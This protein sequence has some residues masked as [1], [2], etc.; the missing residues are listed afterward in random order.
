MGLTGSIY[1]EVLQGVSSEREFERVS[2]YLGSQTFYHPAEPVESYA[3]AARMYFD[4]R[5]AGLT[6]RSSIDCLIA[7]LAIEHGLTLLHDDRDF[8]KISEVIPELALA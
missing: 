4:C 8:E 7:R 1:Q 6:V 5:R 2:E 3:E